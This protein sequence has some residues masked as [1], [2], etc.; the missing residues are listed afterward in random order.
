MSFWARATLAGLPPSTPPSAGSAFDT[1]GPRPP[2]PGVG[3]IAEAL[4]VLRRARETGALV[5]Y[6]PHDCRPC[7]HPWL[8][9]PLSRL[10]VPICML[11]ML[12]QLNYVEGNY[13]AVPAHQAPCGRSTNMRLEISP[14]LDSRVPPDCWYQKTLPATPRYPR[15][16]WSRPAHPPGATPIPS[17]PSAAT[18]HSS[19]TYHLYAG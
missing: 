16:R 13:I 14:I 19:T 2:G 12:I 4:G 10:R 1:S 5:R 18:P 17:L 15:H 6:Y 3:Q 11:L 9:K 7:L 8:G